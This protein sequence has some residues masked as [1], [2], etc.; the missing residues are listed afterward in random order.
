L[1][2]NVLGSKSIRGTLLA[3][4]LKTPTLLKY[5]ALLALV[6]VILGSRTL[7]LTKSN[8]NVGITLL[9]VALYSANPCGVFTVT[10][11][12]VI[13]VLTVELPT[14]MGMLYLF[15]HKCVAFTGLLVDQV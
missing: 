9:R 14:I 3:A 2:A 12:E 11:P 7:E 8:L 4:V 15:Q 10:L 5:V 13:A 1:H 6:K